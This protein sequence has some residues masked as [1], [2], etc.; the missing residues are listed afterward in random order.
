MAAFLPEWVE[1]RFRLQAKS[2][3][4]R[5]PCRGYIVEI[6]LAPRQLSGQEFLVRIECAAWQCSYSFSFNSRPAFRAR[7]F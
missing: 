6:S 1:A 4:A 5:L 3:T 7:I 2:Y